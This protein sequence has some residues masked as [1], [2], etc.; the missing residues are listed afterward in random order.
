M[1]RAVTLRLWRDW[2]NKSSVQNN[3]QPGVLVV[4]SAV[5]TKQKLSLLNMRSLFVYFRC[6]WGGIPLAIRNGVDNNIPS[7]VGALSTRTG[8]VLVSG[9]RVGADPLLFGRTR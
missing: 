7:R 9:T 2:Q 1:G 4:Y 3:S 6:K 8:V 5:I